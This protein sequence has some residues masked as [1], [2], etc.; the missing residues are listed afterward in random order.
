VGAALRKTC[1]QSD[2]AARYGGE[3]FVVALPNTDERGSAVVAE[4][5]RKAIS[6]IP[7]L[8]SPLTASIGVAT[9]RP[10]GESL[11]LPRLLRELI[12]RVD[13]ALY[14]AKSA[15]RN[16]VHCESAVATL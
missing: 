7:G 9:Y 14:A 15:G 16:C 6:N 8:M 10:G 11:P 13:K 4:N 1:R 2:L 3:E 12:S 5:F